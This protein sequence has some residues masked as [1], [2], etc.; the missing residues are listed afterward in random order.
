MH[1]AHAHVEIFLTPTALPGKAYF[2]GGW[3]FGE[4]KWLHNDWVN[5]QWGG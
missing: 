5:V 3:R 2:V 1:L 4:R